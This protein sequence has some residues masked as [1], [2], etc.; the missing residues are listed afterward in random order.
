MTNNAEIFK[1]DK[2]V[3]MNAF[4]QEK[5]LVRQHLDSY[6]VF[7]EK[8]IQEV[9]DEG[10]RIEPD[11]PQYYVKLGRITIGDPTIRE[12]DGSVKP[13]FPIEARIRNL[14]YSAPL[15]LEM[16]PVRKDERTGIE[17]E[18]EVV[19]V[20][21]GRLPIML[22]S[23]G[24][25]LKD[26]SPEELI[27]HGEDPL[28]PGGYF[29]IN[30]SERVL[31]TRE[32]LAPNRILSEEA[33]K[34]LS[35]KYIGK[36]F[37]TAQGFRAPVTIEQRNDGTLRVSFPSVPGKIPFAILVRALGLVTDKEISDAISDDPHVRRPLIPTLEAASPIY[38][39]KDSQATIDNALD[40][41]GKRVAV[42]QTREYRLRRAGQVLDR[43]LLPHIGRTSEDRIK[44]A[45]YLGQMAQRIIE[46]Q[47]KKR[48]PD[49]KDHYANKRLKL[50]G[51]LL[52]S[53][54]RVAFLNLCRDIKYQ[55]E[56]TAVRGR[57]PN[58]RTAVRADVVT[59]RLRHA[60][61]TGNWV[62][63]KAGVSQL[64][65][66][67]NYI[68]A[69]SHLRRVVSPL[70]RSQPHFEAR[71]L[72]PTHWGKICVV[73]STNVLL[74]D[75]V[76]QIRI[77]K[78]EPN[79]QDFIITTVDEYSHLQVPSNI[80]AYQRVSAYELNKRVLEIK[81]ITGRSILATEDHPFLTERGWISA[82]D[83]KLTDKVL[84]RPTLNPT[85][86]IDEIERSV[87]PILDT[88]EIESEKDQE[89]LINLG[90]LPLDSDNPKL[91]IIAR[92]LGLIL[93][94]G[95][96]GNTVEFYLGTE[97]DAINVCRDLEILGFKANPVIYKEGTYQ[98]DEERDPV[99]YGTFQTTKGG[100]FKR[101]MIALGAPIGSRTKQ[102]SIFPVWILNAPKKVK[103]EFL[104]AFMGGDGAAP[105]TYKRKGR[106]DSYKISIPDLEIHKYPNFVDTQIEFFN[107]LKTL[108][109]EF[110]VKINHIKTKEL[111]RD[112]SIAIKLVFDAS[113]DNILRL[114]R[115]IGYRY[116]L[117]K[118]N[119]A[120][121]IEEFLAYRKMQIVKRLNVHKQIINLYN[122]GVQ[123]KQI[124]QTLN[125]GYRIVT[126]IVQ[127]RFQERNIVHPKSAW[128]IGQFFEETHANLDTGLLYSPL[129]SINLTDNDIVCDF[130][131]EINTHTFIANGF[132]THN[133]PNETPE[134]PNCGL[135]KNL[136][137]MAYISVGTDDKKIEKILLE[138]GLQ[139]IE[140]IQ[141]R[142]MKRGF[143]IFLNGRL[144]G[145]HDQPKV[146]VQQIR[147]KRRKNEIDHEVNIA[148]YE[149]IG[150]IQINCD[151]GRAR[152]PCIIVENGRLKLRKEHIDKLKNGEWRWSDLIERG[153][154]EYL[155]AEE[156]ENSFI[157]LKY[158]DLSE[159]H[160]HL[161]IEASTI[162]GITGSLIPYASHNQSPR[163]TYEAGMAKQA[164]GLYAANFGLRVDTRGQL[165]HYPQVPIV[166]TRS[167]E[168]IAFDTRPAGQNFVVAI[169]SFQ[170]YN[171]EDAL[172]INKASIERGL[173]R[174]SFF[175]SYD[176]EERKY[177][178]GQEDRYEIPDRSV[179]GYRAAEA[180]R[181]LG[182]DG[183]I[184]P[185]IEIR[186][187]EVLI[188]RTSPPR[189]L[190]EYREFE[191][192]APTRR[193]TSINLRHGENGVVDKVIITETIDGN[194]LIKVKVRDQ[195]IPELGDKFASRHGQK[196]VLGLIVPQED[197][198]FTEDG[199]VPDLIIN[200]HAIPSR[201]TLGQVIESISGKTA[202]IKGERQD[203]TVFA[204]TL[205]EICNE[206]EKYG[207]KYSGRE[208]MYNGVTGEKYRADIFI[209]IVYYQKLHHMVA[210]KIHAR[211][212]GPVQILTRQP[213]EGRAR[214]G[215]L[216]FGEMERDCLV[217]HGAALLL[218]ERLLEESDKTSILVCSQCG[219][220]AVYDRNRD[221][222]Y[223]PVC[224]DK[225]SINKL[226]VSYAFKLLIQEL[227]SLLVT[228]RLKLKE[229][230]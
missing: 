156:E 213:T 42:G 135:V 122:Q 112:A 50:A 158:S 139:P 223:C 68:S 73:P 155:D 36:V 143:R 217:G 219:I 154:V 193:E 79:Y 228:P 17:I 174:S 140:E 75:G 20:Y 38:V 29:I 24:C 183:I 57:A 44:K 199:V 153:I 85:S 70:S 137:L 149:D 190:E 124:A 172:I 101:L 2:W 160:T 129:A 179:R 144:I 142:G 51:D 18:G 25:L 130:T 1:I 84:I 116:C 6:N 159:E 189:F 169:L 13:I 92:L 125:I 208:A 205:E 187:G 110:D 8:T 33:S 166:K 175:R 195:R 58:I 77:D 102:K 119:K 106:E 4:F 12:A 173:G 221:R 56:R 21:I 43:Y 107:H 11:I 178:G 88:D 114:C 200:P 229:I 170:G 59:E 28:D 63:G 132:V 171:I 206:L 209:G 148:I 134:G 82:G 211:A 48:I 123:P 214:E 49:D 192:P 136:A 99:T 104:G 80:I 225:T 64:L 194:K 32:D 196:G 204:S 115:N 39:P 47:I 152:R 5:G 222:Y 81:T 167:M 126:S 162:L 100:A 9:V 98:F 203:G 215:G 146:F 61:A 150:E 89:K 93:T 72:H 31:V 180:Y 138:L 26:M 212:R 22:R 3:L 216:R 186:G 7:I 53:L 145:L 188:G 16:I 131:T 224:G 128:S 27:K 161:E 220:L 105:W 90:L 147:Q 226:I 201:M 86:E 151:A 97:T 40:Y 62:G 127:R 96:V 46:L 227:T 83:L 54:F 181:H 230:A 111:K 45:F 94:D 52:T 198:P 185:E 19:N 91:H 165:L 74:G 34:S 164:L 60:L 117:E 103:R 87:F 210:D 76:S 113:K 182:E 108:F 67:T 118:Q 15:Y 133:C 121:L 218:K 207:F 66:R 55:L 202:A 177:P 78:I 109:E 191:L 95:Y 37:S 69:L 14:T 197:M 71:D 65:D 23:N 157:A 10:G 176:A 35:A 30:G 163:N 168:A 120:Q 41:I 184:E 141:E